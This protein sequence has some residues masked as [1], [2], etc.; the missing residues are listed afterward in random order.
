MKHRP[1]LERLWE[2]IAV[3]DPGCCWH[4]TAGHDDLGYGRIGRDHGERG[5]RLPHRIVY[6]LVHGPI[7]DEL[8]VLHTC[9]VPS[10]C[11]PGHL[12]VGTDMDNSRDKMQAGRDRKSFGEA[13][14]DAK[15]TDEIVRT[16]RRRWICG[17]SARALAREYGVTPQSMSAALHR[18]TW[19]HVQ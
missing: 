14:H 13:Q 4:W 17:D 6:E 3:G 19:R 16:V 7:P 12:Y 8:L 10:C 1:L 15:L 11:N 2:K 18:K 9:D 5:T